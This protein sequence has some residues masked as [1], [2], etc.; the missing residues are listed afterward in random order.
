MSTMLHTM[1]HTYPDYLASFSFLIYILSRILKPN[2]LDENLSKTE[3]LPILI[4]IQIFIRKKN[5]Y[6]LLQSY[7][8]IVAVSIKNNMDTIMRTYIQV[9]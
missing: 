2:S 4:Q 9:E 6:N 3:K 5:Y 8:T 7:S 1:A